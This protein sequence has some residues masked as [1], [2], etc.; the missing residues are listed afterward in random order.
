MS[1]TA[2][3]LGLDAETDEFLTALLLTM[4]GRKKIMRKTRQ[5]EAQWLETMRGLLKKGAVVIE[6]TPAGE[7]RLKPAL[8]LTV[9][10]PH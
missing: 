9:I 6:Q 1:A 4:K 10:N 2:N 7:I 3:I 5:T 8:G